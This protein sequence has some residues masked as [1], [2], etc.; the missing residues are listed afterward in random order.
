MIENQ[1][2]WIE[3]EGGAT[4]YLIEGPESGP[5]G[6]ALA[7]SE[8]QR[9]NVEE[10]RHPSDALAEAQDISHMPS[11]CQGLASRRLRKVR[12]ASGC[13]FCSTC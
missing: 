12:R 4:R 2:R 9:G 3:I 10:D 8:L 11:I 13:G 5:S 1:S 7:R 6:R